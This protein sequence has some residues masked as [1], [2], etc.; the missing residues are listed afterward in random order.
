MKI[1][2]TA[3]F[4]LAFAIAGP[5][6]AQDVD[7][8]EKVYKKCKACHVVNEAKNRVGP[9]LV[10]IVGREAGAVEDFK[11][12][13]ALL[14]QAEGGL[15]WTEED[16]AAYLKDPRGMIKGTEMSF[17]GLKKDEDIANVIAYLKSEAKED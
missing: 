2:S 4:T 1:L 14:E 17:A 8:G 6:L 3:C 12:S 10:N 7:A 13:K 5:A 9:H 15:V 11:Y 16:L